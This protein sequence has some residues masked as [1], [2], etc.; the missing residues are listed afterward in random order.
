MEV[1][2]TGKKENGEVVPWL[3]CVPLQKSCVRN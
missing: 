1:E 3:E 2:F